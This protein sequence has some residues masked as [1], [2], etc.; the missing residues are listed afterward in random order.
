MHGG[1][2][3]HERK[4]GSRSYPDWQ[5]S[6]HRG[7][8]SRNNRSVARIGD[9]L[10]ASWMTARADDKSNVCPGGLNKRPNMM[11]KRWGTRSL[12]LAGV[13]VCISPST[14]AQSEPNSAPAATPRR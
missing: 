10:S 13:I 2:P 14:T 11:G 12:L 5:H 7:D 8:A 9:T 6:V 3:L 4:L 1:G